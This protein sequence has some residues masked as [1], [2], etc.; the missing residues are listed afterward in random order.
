MKWQEPDN[1][2]RSTRAQSTLCALK[3][4][5]LKNEENFNDGPN[6]LFSVRE[7]FLTSWNLLF[8]HPDSNPWWNQIVP[9]LEIGFKV[10]F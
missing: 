3:D 2:I 4:A 8:C 6:G 9:G 7:E 5:T 10:G 1:E